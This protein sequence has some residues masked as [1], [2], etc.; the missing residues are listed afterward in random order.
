MPSDD[1]GTPTACLCDLTVPLH[2]FRDDQYLVD[3]HIV[4]VMRSKCIVANSLNASDVETP[5]HLHGLV[6]TRRVIRSPTIAEEHREL[7]SADAFDVLLELGGA[8]TGGDPMR[9]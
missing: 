4:K 1:V 2:T 5:S 8:L 7:C 3:S 6:H 9:R